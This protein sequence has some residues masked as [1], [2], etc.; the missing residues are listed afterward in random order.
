MHDGVA[1]IT[2]QGVNAGTYDVDVNYVSENKEYTQPKEKVAFTVTQ[3]IVGMDVNIANVTYGEAVEIIANITTDG[4]P[5]NSGKI[6]VIIDNVAY[7]ANVTNNTAKVTIPKLD[8]GEYASKIL[9]VDD[10]YNTKF[11]AANFTVEKMDAQIGANNQAYIINYGGKYSV[12]NILAG[13]KVSFVLNGKNIG[14]AVA[15]ANGEATIT[16]TA[17]ILKTAKAGSKNLIIKLNEANF[18]NPTKTVKITIN[19]E[20]TKLVAKNKKFKKAKKTKKYTIT[21]KNSKGKAVGKVQVTLKIKGKTYKATTNAKGKA[22]FK[23]KKLSKKGKYKAT[24][25]FKG[26]SYYKAVSKKVKITLK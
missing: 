20:N 19:K 10:N 16:L 1:T 12:K 25:N 13:E 24:V 6:Y 23:I 8:A 4:A 7:V 18:N 14:S 2:L 15:N 5:I 9:F 3:A 22:V 26:N 21:L 11:V 17:G